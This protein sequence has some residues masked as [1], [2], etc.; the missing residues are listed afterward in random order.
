MK[1][2]KYG[3]I[4]P[5]VIMIVNAIVVMVR[6]SSL[7]EELLAHFD[8]QGNASGSMPRGTLL[9]YLLISAVICLIAFGLS[10][11]ISKRNN[12]SSE[13]Q[14]LGLTILTSGIVLAIFSSSMVTLTAGK[15][16]IFMLAEPIIIFLA[17]AAFVICL[18]KASKYKRLIDSPNTS[19]FAHLFLPV[20]SIVNARDLG[21]YNVQDG[22][23]VRSGL[24]IRSAHLAEVDE[25]DLQYLVSLNVKK[26]IDF[27]LEFEKRG[28]VDKI[29]PGAEHIDLPI[30]GSGTVSATATKEEMKKFLGRKTFNVKKVIVMAAFNN[31]AKTIARELYPTLFFNPKCQIQMAAFFRELVNTESGAFL[32]H[33]TQ[34]KDRTGV[35]SALIFAALGVDRETI[36]KDFDVTNKVYENDVKKYSR[37]VKF[38]RGK[39]EELAVVKA[40]IGANTENFVKA[41]DA[42]DAQYGSM[43]AYLKGPMGLTENDII[44][45]RNRY[46]TD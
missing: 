23:Q 20:K 24:L 8:L 42:I 45:L 9:V 2:F 11:K 36:I 27:R 19:D 35:A 16:P 39:E 12:K 25:A 29:V 41:L 14:L 13:L 44:T 33:C 40:F 7:P 32:F 17:F 5:T 38:W 3:W 18:I 1:R 43:E 46:L 37:R 10:H 30:D 26:V 6:W 28:K 21:G 31:K 22:R 4:I 15:M 34:G